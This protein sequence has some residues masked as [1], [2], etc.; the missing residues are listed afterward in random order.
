M[1]QTEEKLICPQKGCV[2]SFWNV[3]S[4]RK[5]LPVGLECQTVGEVYAWAIDGL[6][7]ID[8]RITYE[9]SDVNIKWDVLNLELFLKEE[10][11]RFIHWLCGFTISDDEGVAHNAKVILGICNIEEDLI[12]EAV[13]IQDY[14]EHYLSFVRKWHDIRSSKRESEEQTLSASYKVIIAGGR[15]FNDYELLKEKCDFF[16]KN[17]IMEG[18]RIT[19]ISGHASGADSLGERYAQEGGLQCEQHPADWKTHGKA[20]GF[21][22]NAEM[23]AIADALIAF[24]DGKS[25]G[26]ANMINTARAKGLRVAVIGY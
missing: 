1:K 6:N 26:T 15:D 9:A 21:I 20:A 24:W 14:G 22:R 4:H 19:I 10:F 13:K 17:K 23:A 8:S 12:S 3:I 11:Y 16:L 18:R 7:G 25:R 2:G 5:T